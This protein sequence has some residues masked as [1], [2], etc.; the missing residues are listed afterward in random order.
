MSINESKAIVP[1]EQLPKVII[2]ITRHWRDRGIYRREAALLT[3]GYYTNE[4]SGGIQWTPYTLGLD[5]FLTAEDAWRRT[6]EERLR[7]ITELYDRI[8]KI[9]AAHGRSAN[10]VA[11]ADYKKSDREVQIE[12]LQGK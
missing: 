2:Y 10:L 7:L 5:C 4:E 8:D 11:D 6:S 3:S 1:W 12:R 9:N